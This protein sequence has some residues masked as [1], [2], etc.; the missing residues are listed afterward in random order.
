MQGFH[1]LNVLSVMP[2]VAATQGSLDGACGLYAVIHAIE[3]LLRLSTEQR[4][5]LY[6]NT[7]KLLPTEICKLLLCEGTDANQLQVIADAA[8]LAAENLSLF[9]VGKKVSCLFLPDIAQRK[10]SIFN[11]INMAEFESAKWVIG[12]EYPPFLRCQAQVQG[13]VGVDTDI[14]G[15]QPVNREIDAP[16]G[17]GHWT[18]VIGSS[19]RRLVIYDSDGEKHWI[20]YDSV[21]TRFRIVNTELLCFALVNASRKVKA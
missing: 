13:N 2:K 17:G 3:R 9:P 6:K 1:F 19:V 14:R 21:G 18:C 16:V 4:E 5:S 15:D 7:V 11:A 8:V 10:D 20:N 12:L